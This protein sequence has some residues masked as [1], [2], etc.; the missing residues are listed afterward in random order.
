MSEQV[1]E[2]FL[3]DDPRIEEFHSLS[4]EDKLKV[5]RL[6]LAFLSEGTKHLQKWNSGEWEEVTI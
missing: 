1:V 3:P 2:V 5:V 4:G 6:G